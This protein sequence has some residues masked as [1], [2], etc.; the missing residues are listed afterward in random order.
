MF[1]IDF[2]HL[3]PFN[4]SETV[5]RN[6][7]D[8]QWPNSAG[9]RKTKTS[10]V[11]RFLFQGFPSN[12]NI[13]LYMKEEPNVFKTKHFEAVTIFYNILVRNQKHVKRVTSLLLVADV[14]KNANQS[15]FN[16]HFICSVRTIYFAQFVKFAHYVY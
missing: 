2:F 16:R 13:F 14:E 10:V 11:S 1:S 4:W 12:L 3:C 15:I 8:D 7:C 6:A 9:K 5:I